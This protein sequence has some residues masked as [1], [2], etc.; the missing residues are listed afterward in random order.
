MTDPDYTCVIQTA[1]TTFVESYCCG[2]GG[3]CLYQ[4]LEL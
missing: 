1:G 4:A 2:L 3:L